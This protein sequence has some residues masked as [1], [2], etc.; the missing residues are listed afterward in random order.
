MSNII[1][2][3]G[4]LN[5]IQTK[6]TEIVRMDNSKNGN[7]NFRLKFEYKDGEDTRVMFVYTEND[8][9][10]NNSICSNMLKKLF[11]VAVFDEGAKYKLSTLHQL[12]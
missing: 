8:Y 9:S 11:N 5:F 7:P 10:V 12:S 3:D 6:L 1:K 4:F 2:Q